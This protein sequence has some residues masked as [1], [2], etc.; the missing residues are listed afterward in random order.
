MWNNAR[1][2][3]RRPLRT[4]SSRSVPPLQ[5]A[6]LLYAIASIPHFHSHP[7]FFFC[8][9]CLRRIDYSQCENLSILKKPS[10]G[11]EIM[12]LVLESFSSTRCCPGLSFAQVATPS[13]RVISWATPKLEPLY[14]SEQG[15]TLVKSILFTAH[16]D[17]SEVTASTEKKS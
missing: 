15:G 7:P 16:T 6:N 17:P 8:V 4:S 2:T 13:R 12:L 3:S 10:Q 9:L 1:N 5:I 11:I 14:K